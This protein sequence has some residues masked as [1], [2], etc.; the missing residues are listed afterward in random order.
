VKLALLMLLTPLAIAQTS[1]FSVQNPK[2]LKYDEVQAITAYAQGT[3]AVEREYH[4][5][6][7]LTPKFTLVLGG[8]QG[9]WFAGKERAVSELRLTKWDSAYFRLGVIVLSTNELMDSKRIAALEYRIE[10]EQAAKV[11]VETLKR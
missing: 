1:M 5:L 2:N 6:D 3:S 8:E 10:R 11:D 4:L 9:V 7:H